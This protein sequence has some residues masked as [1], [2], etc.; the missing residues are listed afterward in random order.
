[1]RV[2]VGP[3]HREIGFQFQQ[4][5]RVGVGPNKENFKKKF[6]KFSE[7]ITQKKRG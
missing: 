3:R 2:G 6:N 7:L 4:A 1:M 5:M